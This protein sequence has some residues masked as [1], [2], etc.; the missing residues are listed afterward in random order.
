MKIFRSTFVLLGTFGLGLGLLGATAYS[1]AGATNPA[2]SPITTTLSTPGSSQPESNTTEA[3]DATTDA[4]NTNR[5]EKVTKNAEVTAQDQGNSQADI[6]LVAK[7]R[8]AILDDDSLSVNAENVK[9]VA[10]NGQVILKGPVKSATERTRL[11]QIANDIVGV[12]NVKN[13]LELS[14]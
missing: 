11:I 7:V 6:V 9:I 5:N 3:T 2:T 14:H 12:D 10:K 4:D 1:Q 13:E 8:R